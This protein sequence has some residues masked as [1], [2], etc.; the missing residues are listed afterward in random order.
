MVWPRDFLSLFRCH[1]VLRS[2]LILFTFLENPDKKNHC[3]HVDRGRDL[4]FELN[5]QKFMLYHMLLNIKHMRSWYGCYSHSF[6]GGQKWDII[7]EGVN[8]IK[9]LRKKII[10]PVWVQIFSWNLRWTSLDNI[11]PSYKKNYFKTSYKSWLHWFYL[12]FLIFL[13]W[14]E[15]FMTMTMCNIY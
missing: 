2:V 14:G 3:V 8:R 9:T 15:N 1:T 4:K 13:F 12:P 6:I 10:S 5:I 11:T 7:I